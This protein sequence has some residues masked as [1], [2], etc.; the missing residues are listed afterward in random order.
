MTFEASEWSKIY[1]DER[2]S[3]TQMQAFKKLMPVAFAG[4][5]RGMRSLERSESRQ[6][7]REPLAIAGDR[8]SGSPIHRIP[9][10]DGEIQEIRVQDGHLFV[11]QGCCCG[12]IERGFA[13]VP[14]DEFK[15]QWK[16]RGIRQRFHLTISGCLGPCP[17]ANVVLLYFRGRSTWLHSINSAADITLIYD[18]AEA[19]LLADCWLPPPAGL[20]ERHFQR[21][22]A[23]SI[24][25]RQCAV[26]P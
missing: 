7:T 24:D 3:D 10:S 13:P 23:D 16:S 14:L 17:M 11:C 2:V 19:M 8:L 9:R 25:Q 15:Q 22:L 21:Y 12:N 18:H 5:H 6:D 26:E 1:V 4:F 20:Q